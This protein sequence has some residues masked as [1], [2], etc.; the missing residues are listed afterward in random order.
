VTR[1]TPKLC[2]TCK[3]IIPPGNTVNHG[4]RVYC[5]PHCQLKAQA[6]RQQAS[7]DRQAAL[8]DAGWA[9][10][11]KRE[12]DKITAIGRASTK[13]ENLN[14]QVYAKTLGGALDELW[15]ATRAEIARMTR[16]LAEQAEQS[17]S[18]TSGSASGTNGNA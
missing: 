11:T 15:K 4:Q 5:S 7:K 14:V 16:E 12:G 6:K 9:V 8:L 13:T 18:T 10:L 3:Q 1:S 2:K 17:P